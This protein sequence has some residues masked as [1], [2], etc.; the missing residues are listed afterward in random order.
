MRNMVRWIFSSRPTRVPEDV[1]PLP[2]AELPPNCVRC[3]AVLA[4]RPRF[5]R[6]RVCDEC[7]KHYPIDTRT[8]IASLVDPGSFRE[9]DA[10]L[11]S[12]DPLQFADDLPYHERLRE[13]RARTELTDGATIGTA[14]LHGQPIVIAVLDFAFMGGSMG[15]VV[16]EKIT[17]AAELAREK[18]RPLITI[19]A[20]GGARMQEGLFSLLQMAKTAAAMQQLRRAGVP[21][22]SVLTHPTTGGV[23]A[24][25]ASLGDIIVAEPGALIGFAGPRVVEQVLGK[26]L[27]PGSHSAEFLLEHGIIDEVVERTHLRRYLATVLE[28]IWGSNAPERAT[29]PSTPQPV[30][31][32]PNQDIWQTV[33]AAR[34]HDRPMTLDYITRICDQFLELHG[35]RESGDDPAVIAGL[36]SI[37][38]RH[39]ALVGFERGHAEQAEHRRYG[40]PSPDGYRKAQRIMHLAARFHLPV[41]TLIDTPGAYP[42]VEAEAGGLAAEIAETMALLSDLPTPIV[43]AIIGEGGSGG[44]LALAVADRVLMQAHAIYSVIA[45]EGAAA[46][47]YRDA[48]RAPELAQ[49][50][51]LTAQDCLAA[52]IIDVIVP[53]PAGGAAAAPDRAADLLSDAVFSAL[54]QVAERPPS[55][56]VQSRGERYR[57]YGRAYLAHQSKSAHQHG[58]IAAHTTGATRGAG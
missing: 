43:A 31:T 17:R 37:A 58:G 10:D 32:E 22:L 3:G 52:G 18:R 35:D 53:E 2:G 12:T 50:L 27:P 7:G 38:D 15:V 46:I 57:G 19:V 8:R 55:R 49:K 13:Q 1:S 25:F 34:A 40:R 29:A 41:V 42:G 39:V 4:G 5:T 26:P 45:P 56:L 36:G 14:T 44:A 9:I 54:T 6:L 28:L 20:S 11:V 21:F 24:S 47:L 30:D 48:E 23:F 33:Q 16:G 51:K